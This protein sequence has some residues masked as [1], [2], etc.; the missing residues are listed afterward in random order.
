MGLE[1][2]TLII[3]IALMLTILVILEKSVV[4]PSKVGRFE[5]VPYMQFRKDYN[6]YR[7]EN[8]SAIYDTYTIYNDINLPIRATKGSA[9]YDFYSPVA[10]VLHAGETI[11][12]PTGVCAKINKGWA[13]KIYPRSSMGFKYQTVLANTVGIIDSDYYYGDNQGHIW[14]KLVNNG[15]N[16]LIV[17]RGDRIV[18]GIFEPY[19][20]TYGDKAEARRTGG[21]GSSGR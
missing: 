4:R 8:T 5:R 7:R 10:F 15:D 6:D 11:S 17:K 20:V 14:V 16:D 21:F 3:I 12:F 9:G 2:I 13:L 19:G 18:Q 1:T